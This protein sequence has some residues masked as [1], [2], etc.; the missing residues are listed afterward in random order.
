MTKAAKIT[1]YDRYNNRPPQVKSK[2][3][4]VSLT[5]QQFKDDAD[6]NVIVKK[7]LKSG[8]DPRFI[9]KR[10]PMYGDFAKSIDL[11]EAYKAID[12]AEADFLEVPAEVREEFGNDP[13]QFF[14]VFQSQEKF[15][16][17][18]DIFIKHGLLPKS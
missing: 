13:Q 12:K 4:G 1:F 8:S 11:G 3:V 2:P 17:N 6:I 16:K 9:E 5:K 7:Y 18:K 14:E 10:Q 15:E